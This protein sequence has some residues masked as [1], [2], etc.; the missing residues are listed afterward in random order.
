MLSSQLKNVG[1]LCQTLKEYE[2]TLEDQS[3]RL[4]ELHGERDL[5]QQHNEE[6]DTASREL[7]LQLERVT[8]TREALNTRLTELDQK[9]REKVID[10]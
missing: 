7:N 1:E 10:R 4:Q 6:L 3:A 8:S 9:L 5:L 2:T